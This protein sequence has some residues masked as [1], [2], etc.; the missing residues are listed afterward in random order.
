MKYYTQLI[1][2]KEGAEAIFQSFEE[3]VLPIMEKYDGALLYRV[4]PGRD[5]VV[6]SSLGFPTE[7]HLITFPSR[8]DFEGY[9]ADKDRLQFMDLKN[10][11][12][13]KVLLI[14]GMAI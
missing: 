10:E 11:S 6:A 14:E 7:V 8:G 9:I 4:R 1:Y 2:V 5:N 13:L 12:V 3:H